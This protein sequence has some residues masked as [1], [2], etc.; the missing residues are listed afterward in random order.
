MRRRDDGEA[1]RST[2]LIDPA[3]AGR[4]AKMPHGH[5]DTSSTASHRIE[6]EFLRYT[7][8]HGDSGTGGAMM[9]MSHSQ[10]VTQTIMITCNG[11][12]RMLP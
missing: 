3:V 11:Q 1:E 8:I 7:P 4:D 12:S 6:G 5:N 10:P 2:H 9:R